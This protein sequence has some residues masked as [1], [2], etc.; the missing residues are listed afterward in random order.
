MDPRIVA[1]LAI[2][3][4]AAITVIR[5]ANGNEIAV[6][7]P[8]VAND[9]V[10]IAYL[11]LSV[12]DL[13]AAI[14]QFGPVLGLPADQLHQVSQVAAAVQSRI[15]QFRQQG[16][17][18]VYVLLR[19]ADIAY[20]GPTWIAPVKESELLQQIVGQLDEL[21]STEPPRNTSLL[22]AHF[23]T[24]NGL[25]LAASTAEQLELLKASRWTSADIRSDALA[26]LVQ[27]DGHAAGLVLFG[28]IDSRRSHSRIV[29]TSLAAF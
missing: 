14:E 17:G 5:C 28:D 13:P 10:G 20:G 12:V 25:V 2:A 7:Q 3:S 27:V 11:D 9:V 4:V 21:V 15:E 24:E 29:S 26:A 16:V 23:A 19:T 6:V 1:R 8:Y 18:R 22:P